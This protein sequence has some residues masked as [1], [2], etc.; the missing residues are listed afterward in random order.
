MNDDRLRT[1]ASTVLEIGG[2]PSFVVDLR[3]PIPESARVVF[4][5]LGLGD[6][7]A[8]VTAECPNGRPTNAL[9]NRGR[10]ANLHRELVRCGWF[11][12]VGIGM[13]ADSLHH[14]HGYAIRCSLAEAIRLA[15]QC[16]Q[17]AL[18]W[19]SGGSFQLVD[20][21]ASRHVHQLPL[22]D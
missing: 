3:Y 2:R 10:T 18:F 15:R 7:F 1:Y 16:R 9:E 4:A 14:E 20:V 21:Q 12:R 11:H 8:V 22:G 6:A 19:Y 5:F 13:D 17:E